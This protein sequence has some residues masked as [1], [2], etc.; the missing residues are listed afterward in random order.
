MPQ[1]SAMGCYACLSRL[2]LFI[3]LG[4]RLAM[5]HARVHNA[6]VIIIGAGLGGLAAAISAQDAGLTTVVLEAAAEPG[7]LARSFRHDGYTFDC[8]GHLLH[9]AHSAT[10]ELVER[11]TN[12]S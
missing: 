6:D 11:H 1:R 7:G 3:N 10:R 12:L 4:G 8:S 5:S 2:P 9:L